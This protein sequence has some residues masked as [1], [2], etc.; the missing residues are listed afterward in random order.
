MKEALSSY[1]PPGKLC[2]KQIMKNVIGDKSGTDPPGS[3][4]LQV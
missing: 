3:E 2:N 1:I 4:F